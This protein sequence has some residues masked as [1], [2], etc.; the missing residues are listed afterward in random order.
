MGRCAKPSA[1][2]RRPPGARGAE[3]A[4]ASL[5]NARAQHNIGAAAARPDAPLAQ[6]VEDL[7]R[8]DVQAVAQFAAGELSKLSNRL[9]GV[10][11]A[12]ENGG[13]VSCST[14]VV[15]GTMFHCVLKSAHDELW[16]VKVWRKLDG[17]YELS[18][19]K[20]TKAEQ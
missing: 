9:G 1:A 8:E 20:L 16:E 10:A 6:P 7:A 3:E 13:V 4:D 15:A 5:P 12:E 18:D 11:L 2:A 17:T 19:S 14:Q